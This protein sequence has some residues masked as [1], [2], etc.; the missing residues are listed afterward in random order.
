ML[1]FHLRPL[2]AVVVADRNFS[3]HTMS[4]HALGRIPVAVAEAGVVSDTVMVEAASVRRYLGFLKVDCIDWVAVVG[5][6]C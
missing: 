5:F 1:T 2:T 6:L 4:F 3:S